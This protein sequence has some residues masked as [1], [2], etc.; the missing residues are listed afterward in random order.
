MKTKIFLFAIITCH[1]LSC[2]G[3]SGGPCEPSGDFVV[4]KE[5]VKNR[6]LF[7]KAKE[8]EIKDLDIII[9]RLKA[10]GKYIEQC[11][12]GWNDKWSISLFT[13]KKY[14][15]YKDDKSVRSY[16]I[17]GSWE[18][19]YL[20]EYSNRKKLLTRYPLDS[21]KQLVDKIDLLP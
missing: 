3:L 1:I 9:T 10:T 17:D 13:E 15:S 14:A 8:E 16:V 7:I 18:K 6:R 5:D 11:K 19:S 2:A 4:L 20:A 21:D 12:S